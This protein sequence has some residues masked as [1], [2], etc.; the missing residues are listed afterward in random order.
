MLLS[1]EECTV[2]CCDAAVMPSTMSCPVI[3]YV[4]FM[5]SKMQEDARTELADRQLEWL[6]RIED[7]RRQRK[8]EQ[9]F[10]AMKEVR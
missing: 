5:W 3:L 1:V 7:K 2:V 8:R 10:M 6:H 4:Y 9:E